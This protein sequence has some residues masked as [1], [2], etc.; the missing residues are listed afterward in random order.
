MNQRIHLNDYCKN[1]NLAELPESIAKEFT[2][3]T[4]GQGFVSRR[5]IA[6][7]SGVHHSSVQ[8]L[9]N[10]ISSGGQKLPKNLKPFAGQAFDSGDQIPDTVAS[11]IIKY[12]SR[13]G[14]ETAQDTDDAIGAIG[15]RTVIQK[16]LGWEAPRKLTE[17]EIVELM[18]LPVPTDWQPRFTVEYYNELSRLTKLTPIGHKRPALWAKITKELVYDYMPK[19]VYSEIKAWQLATDPNKKLH[20]YLSDQGIEALKAH[21]TKVI[22]VMQCSPCLADVILS[23][24]HC[25]TKQYQLTLLSND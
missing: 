20:Q 10:L 2:V 22:T 18:C 7:L 17:R 11:A 23:L 13:Q 14:K 5:G 25:R 6:R 15:L 21:L 16:T 3:N 9:L 24:E 12:Y 4:Q 19:G 1:M 8:N